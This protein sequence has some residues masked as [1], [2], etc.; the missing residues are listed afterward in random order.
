MNTKRLILAI[1]VMFIAVFAM[2]LLIHGVWLQSAYKETMSLWRAESEMNA[3]FGWMLLGQFL[4]ASTFA[5]IWAAGFAERQCLRCAVCYGI[6]MALFN[7]AE[8]LI[9]YVVMPLPPSLAVKWFVAGIA[10][11]LVMG[12]LVYYLYKP[13]PAESKSTE[14]RTA[15]AAA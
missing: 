12:V 10:Q 15:P 3:R 1:V 9:N 13:K 2:N 4:F 5:V 11:G 14:Q 8:T 7:Q 6:L